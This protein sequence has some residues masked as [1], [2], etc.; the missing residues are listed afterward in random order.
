MVFLLPYVEQGN[1]YQQ[2]QFTGGNSGYVNGVNR[3]LTTANGGLVLNVYRCPSSALPMFAQ[4]GGLKV[5]QSNYVGISGAANGTIPASG[6]QPAYLETRIDNS[7]A[8][9][10]CCSGAG[11]AS[12]GGVLFRGS[13]V[14]LTEILDGTSNTMMASEHGDWFFATDGGRRQWSAAGLYGWSMGTNTNNPP[15]APN[16]TGNDNRQFNCTTIRYL[17]NQKTGWD[18]NGGA[19]TQSGDCR[20][21]VCYDMGNNIPLNS[22]HTG[23]V[24]AV[25]GDGS[26]R[27]LSSTTALDI[28]ARLAVRD[29]GQTVNAP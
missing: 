1:L 26:V 29:D 17:I 19:G 28:L 16:A 25:Y 24:N 4:N 27:F 13:A 12:G 11:P 15:N 5:M 6:T 8:G 20:V 23:G 2:W 18:P 21:G 9:I 7:A 22:T 10:N 3:A 14:K